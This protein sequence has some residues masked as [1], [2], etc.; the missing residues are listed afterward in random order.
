MLIRQAVVLFGGCLLSFA[1]FAGF[2]GEPTR[3][4][5]AETFPWSI[6]GS[7]GYAVLSDAYAGQGQTP[8]GRIAVGKSLGDLLCGVFGLE[9]GFQNGTSMQLDIP[10]ATLNLLGGVPV[11]VT[12]NPLLD[13]LAT[14]RVAPIPKS[15]VFGELKLGAA[16]R[17]M[18]V[19]VR[20][21]VNNKSQFAF[22]AQ[23]GLGVPIIEAVTVSLLY[24]GIFGSSVNFQADRASRTGYIA[25]I[26]V[27]NGVLLSLS[28]A[29]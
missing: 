28:A 4:P 13:L 20:E 5:I 2:M 21:T 17:R 15:T 14:V 19:L 18:N 22:E 8:I 25:N 24:Q 26:P 29:F 6:T 7:A 12:V 1:S 27:Q 10:E 11:T 23:A 3:Q 16:Y 9:F